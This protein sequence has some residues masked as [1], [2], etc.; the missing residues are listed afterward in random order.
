MMKSCMKQIGKSMSSHRMLMDYSNKFY[1]PALRNYRRL[2]KDDYAEGKSLAAYMSK[3][4]QAWDGINILKV[5]SNAKP[6]MQRGDSLT[7]TA[8]IDLGPLQ[9]AD[10]L[11]ELYHGTVSSQGSDI[12]NARCSEMKDLSSEGGVYQ[13]QVR[14]E[15]VDTGQQGHTVRIL[16]KHDAL[17]HPYRTGL[18][19]WA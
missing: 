8:T 11:V 9:P 16:P 13:Y 15:C 19:K 1:F 7:V 14:I 10:L 18:I 2:V 6:V 12:A 4:Q 5:E 3:L 17:V